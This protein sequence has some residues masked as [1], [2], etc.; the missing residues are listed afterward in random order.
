MNREF[1]ISL[2]YITHDLTTAYQISD[3]II[4]LYRGS[5]AEAGAAE[6]VVQAPEHPYTQLLIGS[7]PLPDPDHAWVEEAGASAIGQTANPAQGCKF[8]GRCPHAM[9]MCLEQPP[10]LFRTDHD[11]AAAC[12]LYRE[13]PA[14]TDERLDEVFVKP[15]ES[16]RAIADDNVHPHDRS[17]CNRE[18]VPCGVATRR[19]RCCDL[20][21]AEEGQQVL[22]QHRRLLLGDPVPGVV[23]HHRLH[24]RGVLRP[25]VLHEVAEADRAAERQHR[26]LQLRLG[27][28]LGLLDVGEEGPVVLETGPHPPLGRVAAHVLVDVL[29]ADRRRVV[30][31]VAVEPRQVEAFL[32]GDQRLRQV[33]DEVEREVPETALRRSAW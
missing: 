11:R 17:G 8:A 12:Y 29:L 6:P 13:A 26:H 1:G 33:A 27:V 16:G 5:V 19:R 24:V 32:A 18:H 9:E 28:F 2:I 14:L 23:D 30:G 4:V 25:L 3:N 20:P 7:I 31:A 10:P 21:F 15:N 22:G